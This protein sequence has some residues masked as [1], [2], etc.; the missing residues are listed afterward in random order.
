MISGYRAEVDLS[1]AGF[2]MLAVVRL[3]YPSSR[4][5]PLRR[6]LERRPEIAAG[7][8]PGR[9]SAPDVGSSNR[10]S[11]C[12]TGSAAYASAGKSATTSTKPSSPSPAPSSAG[13]DSDT[14]RV[15]SSKGGRNIDGTL[16]QV[17][18]ELATF[19]STT[20]SLVYSATLPYRAAH[21]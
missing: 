20:T 4:L 10:P 19:G 5:E 15:R 6:L 18:N 8:T 21:A 12:C 16:E 1:K 2:A 17:V 13:D 9:R 3:K 11:P 7:Q 14:Q